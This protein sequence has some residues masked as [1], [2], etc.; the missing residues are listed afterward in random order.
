[1]TKEDP[2]SE[3]ERWTYLW[4]A[5]YDTYYDCYYQ[6]F[7]AELL[8][9]RWQKFDDGV[10]ILVAL[11][12]SSSAVAGWALWNQPGLRYVW[13]ALAGL[14]AVLSIVHAALSVPGRIREWGDILRVFAGL[15]IDCETL[16]FRMKLQPLS[17]LEPLTEEFLA[18]RKRYAE[19]VQM[20][21]NDTLRTGGLRARAQDLLN[22]KL[23]RDPIQ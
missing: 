16:Q 19:G 15:R 13:V 17:P 23:N 10:R 14:T 1:M 9:L 7:E 6:E 21:K 3:D 12:A 5:V 4:Q 2:S 11:T 20:L 18:I 8:L 22:G